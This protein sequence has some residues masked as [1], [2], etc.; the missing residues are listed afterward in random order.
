[1]IVGRLAP[2]ACSSPMC[3]V[4]DTPVGVV[5]PGPVDPASVNNEV[6]GDSNNCDAADKVGERIADTRFNVSSFVSVSD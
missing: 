6:S 2:G 4:E 5:A 3:A 1:M